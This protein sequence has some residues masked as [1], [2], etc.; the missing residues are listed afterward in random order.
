MAAILS[1][2]QCVNDAI[3]SLSDMAKL[4]YVYSTQSSMFWSMAGLRQ[5][6]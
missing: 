6:S 4:A 3:V 2:P 1:R 5:G